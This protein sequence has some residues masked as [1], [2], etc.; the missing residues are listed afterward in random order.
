MPEFNL[1]KSAIQPY[2]LKEGEEYMNAEQLAHFADILQDWKKEL[3]A[4]VERTVGHLRD[5]VT[6]HAD[7]ADRA[8]QEEEFAIVLRTRDRERKLIR[9]I[10]QAMDRIQKQDYG[11]CDECGVEIGLRRLEVR[12]TATLCIDCKEID[13]VREKQRGA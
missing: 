5:E 11:Y 4:E 10:D 3:Q 2:V 7:P 9:K 1:T 6:S 12:P 13:E 8:S